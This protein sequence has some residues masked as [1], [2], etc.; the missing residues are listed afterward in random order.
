MSLRSPL[1]RVRGLGSAKSGAHHWLHQRL[2][3]IAIVPLSLW[4]VNALL[5]HMHDDHATLV[6]WIGSPLV[7]A[8]LIALLVAVFYHAKLGLQVVIED[9][10]HDDLVKVA[11]LVAMKLGLAFG[12]LLGV[13]A[14]LKISFGSA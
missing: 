4:F 11:L 6:A 8:L 14:V 9:Y 3:A 10:F 7:A 5:T 2:T 1:G 12:A 13:V